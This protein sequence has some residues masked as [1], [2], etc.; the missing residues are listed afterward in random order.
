MVRT[1]TAV[2][3][4]PSYGYAS[5]DEISPTKTTPPTPATRT[6]RS[7]TPSPATPLP[8]PIMLRATESMA[9][10]SQ[11]N[12]AM[13]GDP[14]HQADQLDE[15]E[16]PRVERPRGA[17]DPERKARDQGQRP[18]RPHLEPAPREVPDFRASHGEPGEERADRGRHPHDE[19]RQRRCVHERRRL[20]A[21]KRQSPA[22]PLHRNERIPEIQVV[23]LTTHLDRLSLPPSGA[24]A[25]WR[26]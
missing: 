17:G 19:H 9:M 23:A 22:P 3:G 11:T 6:R 16:R 5:A 4:P 2:I 1:V 12:T 18:E 15:R 14:R 7:P 25:P 21:P 8:F 24:S 13:Q 10:N 26:P 20:P